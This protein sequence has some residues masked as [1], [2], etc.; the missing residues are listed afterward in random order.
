ME[1]KIESFLSS[2]MSID[3][4]HLH[5]KL[6][7][8]EIITYKS[9]VIDS[10]ERFINI[11]DSQDE[12]NNIE[13]KLNNTYVELSSK[14]SNDNVLEVLDS[15]RHACVTFSDGGLQSLYINQENQNW[16]PK[17]TIHQVLDVSDLSSFPDMIAVFRGCDISEYDSKEYG[18]SWSTDLQAAS[19]FAFVHYQHQPWFSKSNRIVL[20]SYI[21]KSGV[22]FSRQSNSEKEVVVDTR[23]LELVTKCT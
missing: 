14:V 23:K 18:Q 6:N 7:S 9:L 21:P 3:L 11:V 15:I 8:D 20:K 2:K 22:F 19:D 4:A 1:M 17:V 5:K 16:Y 12:P 10:I 13:R